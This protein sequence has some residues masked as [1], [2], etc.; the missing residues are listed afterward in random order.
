MDAARTAL[1]AATLAP[2]EEVL[3]ALFDEANF[4]PDE[5]RR[6]HQRAVKLV[7]DIRA[8]T[9]PSMMEL[10]LA[11]YGLSSEEGVALMCL[12]EALLRVPDAQ[13]IDALIE[14]K[15]APSEWGQH[16]G[17]SHSPLINASTW[18]LFLTGKVLKEKGTRSVSTVLHSAIK[19]LGEPVIRTAVK[20]AMRELGRQFV[21]GET[22]EGAIETAAKQQ[23][24]G[25]SF[26]YDMLGE[27][28]RTQADAQRYHI[29][30]A[31]AISQIAQASTSQNVAENPGISIKLS[32]LH[33]R[34]EQLKSSAVLQ[35]LVPRALALASLAKS[36]NIGLNIDAEEAARLDLSLDVIEAVLSD[37]GLVGWDGFG[38]VVQAYS[39]RA[40]GIIDWLYALAK[41]L[42][43]RIMV[44]LV[45]G[46]YWD[47]EIK[48]AQVEGLEGFPVFTRK[49]ATDVSYLACARKL[50][51]MGDRIYP[52]FATHNAHSVAAILEMG[53]APDAFEFQ[54]LHGMGD[55]LHAT[56]LARHKTRCRI[57]APVGAHKD[58]LAYLVRRLLENGANSSFVNQIVDESVAPEIVAAD[59]IA[60]ALSLLKNAHHSGIARPADLF[61]P[62]RRNSAGWDVS[63]P[64][65]LAALKAQI[66]AQPPYE[67]RH[68]DGD[69]TP[70]SNPANG[71]IIGQ[72]YF[73][74][75]EQAR[76]TVETARDWSDSTSQQRADVLL[77]A[78]DLF[79]AHSAPLFALM[80]REAGKTLVDCIGERREA[81]DFL[82]YYAEQ[83]RHRETAPI[84]L[85]SCISPWNFPLA[86][87]T[88]QIVAALSM[89]NGVI[90]KPAESTPLIADYAVD[91]LYQAGVPRDVLKLIAGHGALVGPVLTGHKN[92]GG[93]CFT[94]STKTAQIINRAMA[95]ALP[96]N[97]PLIAETGGLN[98]MIVDSTSLP[99]QAVRDVIASA[100]QSAGQRC[101]ALRMLYLQRDIAPE[102]LKMLQGAMKCLRL[103]DPSDF[104]TDIGPVID[105]AAK[106]GI[107]AHVLE[108]AE[109]GRLILQLD[110]PLEGT[111]VA[112][113]LVSIEGIGALKKEIFGPV[114]HIALY[115]SADIDRVIDAVNGAGYG[116][117][118]GLHTRIDGRV[119]H[120]IDRV[121]AGNIYVNR[122]QIGAIV[123]SQPFGGHGLSGTGPK[124]GGPQYLRRFTHAEWPIEPCDISRELPG[125]TGES[126]RYQLRAKRHI[127]CLGPSVKDGETQL[128]LAREAG[129]LGARLML[130]LPP[131]DLREMAEMDAVI[132]WGDQPEAMREALAGRDGAIVPLITSRG[133]DI[134]LFNEYSVSVDTTAAGGNASLLAVE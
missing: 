114:L 41:R 6:F 29:A 82:R 133:P 69:P 37:Q 20:R 75:A 2:E 7:R 85:F 107:D 62:E 67:A 9:Q 103:G 125:P 21:L 81:V 76:Q 74:D 84:G 130:D 44:R 101:S 98:A 79:E 43:R 5:Q 51:G 35:E 3:Q 14:D 129:S 58:L 86:I 31:D 15:I 23:K 25:Y 92:I 109:Q 126:N 47:S 27:A 65:V 28:A 128:K 112:P 46:A 10:F 83:A 99:E 63:D 118:F 108:A 64:L 119:Q 72:A 104:A 54:R 55:A 8:Q 24:R 38:V 52:Q 34:Y 32:A 115:D 96:D 17:H 53:A 66:S 48:L 95:S 22:I 132:Y 113:A 122:N 73:A 30:Y 116:L 91:L 68:L 61:M 87:F 12:A 49:P 124:A 78:A 16:L 18:T 117:T 77:R 33:P 97:P 88:G 36:A 57:Y 13:T 100:F 123:G 70:I 131:S 89:G 50:L 90:A 59:P 121:K 4:T 120:V 26:S 39:K 19:R 134:R 45:K 127:L 110:A 71:Q 93:V 102:F 106:A 94:G 60:K 1:R 40:S 11:E 80:M 105:A 42:D 111:F 56:V